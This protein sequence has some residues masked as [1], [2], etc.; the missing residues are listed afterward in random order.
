MTANQLVFSG[1]LAHVLFEIALALK[2]ENSHK[3]NALPCEALAGI[4]NVQRDHKTRI[5]RLGRIQ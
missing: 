5:T 1:F 3:H 2:S 4:R